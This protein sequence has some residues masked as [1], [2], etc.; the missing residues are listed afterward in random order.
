MR[1]VEADTENAQ[2]SIVQRFEEELANQAEFFKKQVQEMRNN[3]D[4][5]IR[6]MQK[7]RARDKTDNELKYKEL[8]ENIQMNSQ[9]IL[10]H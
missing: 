9:D 5:D 3:F 4:E 10:K 7:L 8:E 1:K 6:F 2:K